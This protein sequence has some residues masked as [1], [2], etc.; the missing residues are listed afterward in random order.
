MDEL[1]KAYAL[2]NGEITKDITDAD[3]I[4]TEK[5]IDKTELGCKEDAKCF[6]VTDIDEI[7]ANFLI[8]KNINEKEIEKEKSN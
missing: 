1:F 5:P 2:A 8:N 4:F 7:K 6:S 3:F